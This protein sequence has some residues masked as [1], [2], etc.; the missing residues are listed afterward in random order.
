MKRLC[1]KRL[2]RRFN[3]KKQIEKQKRQEKSFCLQKLSKRKRVILDFV[4]TEKKKV[5]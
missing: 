1:L 5:T 3:K 2:Q 4:S